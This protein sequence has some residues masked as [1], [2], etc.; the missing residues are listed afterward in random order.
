[1]RQGRWKLLALNGEPVELFDMETD[2][3]EQHNLVDQE[4]ER[5]KAL[6]RQLAAWLAEPRQGYGTI[7]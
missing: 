6:A 4:P 7:K 2:I 3:G 1:V 5:V